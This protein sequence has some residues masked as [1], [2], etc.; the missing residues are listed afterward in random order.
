MMATPTTRWLKLAHRL[1]RHPNPLRRRSDILEAWLLPA[2]C[3]AFLLLGPLIA[4][5]AGT[6]VHAENAAVQRAEQSWRPVPA[7]LLRA[8]PG[9]EVTD[10]GANTWY[11]SALARWTVDGRTRVGDIPVPAGSSA[12]STQTAWLDAAGRVQM[13]PLTPAQLGDAT[14]TAV[15]IALTGLAVVI[16]ILTVLVKWLLDRRR[17]ASWGTAWLAVE[18]RWSHQR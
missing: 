10:H 12:G 8:A 9:P 5:L 13:P 11:E 15:L 16:G 18:P 6:W 14:V 7:V 4:V 2:A 1:G 17:L 3:A